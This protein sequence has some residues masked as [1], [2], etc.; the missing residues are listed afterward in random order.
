MTA[1]TQSGTSWTTKRLLEWTSQYL[2]EAG[3]DQ[4][5]LCAEVLLA[6]ILECTRIEL[7]IRFDYCPDQEQLGRFR[8]LVKRAANHEPVQYLTGKAH[9]YS[10]E[11]IVSP[12]VLIP[13]A[14][15]ELLVS[16]AVDFCRTL[17]LRPTVDVLDLCTGS[18]CVA[19]AL[20]A[21]VIETD[22]IAM[23]RSSDALEIAR[24]NLQ[25]HDFQN[26]VTLSQGDLFAG[27]A[28]ADKTVFDLI[29]ANPPY[30][31]ADEF[32]K[33][34]SGVRNYE[35]ADALRAGDD[36]LDIIRRIVA[37]AETHLADESAL[38]L[39][40]AY[41]QAEA[42]VELCEQAGYLKDVTTVRDSLGHRR[43][44]TARKE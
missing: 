42:V 6:H 14:E 41:N 11:L 33:L 21:N 44:V 18:G 43:V 10:L 16:Q 40:I 4:T 34:E 8:E 25:T 37:G 26:R 27:L 22:I 38:M 15:T 23:D 2:T 19:V 12:A 20:A 30:I 9:F 35:P 1:E 32:E 3:V 13:R 31:A 39:E 7:Y 28:Q 24:Q 36:G 29:V 5:R 17:M